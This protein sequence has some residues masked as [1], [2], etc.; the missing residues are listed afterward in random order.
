MTELWTPV[1]S[2]K[3]RRLLRNHVDED[4]ILARATVAAVKDPG[5][6]VYRTGFNNSFKKSQAEWVFAAAVVYE[7]D[8][9]QLRFVGRDDTVNCAEDTILSQVGWYPLFYSRFKGRNE[10]E[11]LNDLRDYL[12][13]TSGKF[14][15]KLP[16]YVNHH[17]DL[18]RTMARSILEGT[19]KIKQ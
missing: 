16:L 9:L 7:E 2:F 4:L 15:D 11:W 12:I 8:L 19:I 6:A 14:F 13:V 5:K 1:Q 17:Y 10:S 3:G 18:V